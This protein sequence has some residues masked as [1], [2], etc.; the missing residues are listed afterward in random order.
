VAWQMVAS[1][2]LAF[3]AVVGRRS[4][5]L[6][7]ASRLVDW[8]LTASESD[9]VV[10]VRFFRVNSLIDSPL[11]LLHPAFLCRAAAVNMR[12]GRAA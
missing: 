10:A 4:G 7:V 2:D 1:L 6:R 8:A 3:P 9:L 11:R 5:W 12:R